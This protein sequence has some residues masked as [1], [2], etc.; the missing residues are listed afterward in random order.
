MKKV[1][2]LILVMAGLL[3]SQL[4]KERVVRTVTVMKDDVVRVEYS[5]VAK[6]ADGKIYARHNGYYV[7]KQGDNISSEPAEVQSICN[8]AWGQ[9]QGVIVEVPGETIYVEVPGETVYV[10]VPSETVYVN[11]P[12]ETPQEVIDFF[13]L[14]VSDPTKYFYKSARDKGIVAEVQEAIDLLQ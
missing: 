1:G 5:D 9:T 13:N 6:E 8:T 3:F 12:A 10:D 11:V 4:S 7:L 14:L 2:I